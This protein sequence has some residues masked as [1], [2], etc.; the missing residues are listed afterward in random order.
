[1]FLEDMS[2]ESVRYSFILLL[3]QILPDGKTNGCCIERLEKSL[4]IMDT[5]LKTLRFA[6]VYFLMKTVDCFCDFNHQRVKLRG[7]AVGLRKTET[8]VTANTHKDQAL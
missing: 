2:S 7:T 1:M 6:S 8:E 5:S 3:K 4:R